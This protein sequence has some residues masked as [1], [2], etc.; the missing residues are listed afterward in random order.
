MQKAEVARPPKAL[1]QDVLQ[2]QPKESGAAHRA[3]HHLA[4]LAVAVALNNNSRDSSDLMKK[5][6][7]ATA[8][9]FAW[10]FA[11]SAQADMAVGT[12][13]KLRHEEWNRIFA[14]VAFPDEH[15]SIRKYDA[16]TYGRGVGLSASIQSGYLEQANGFRRYF[17]VLCQRQD[18][19]WTCQSPREFAEIDG[20]P[21]PIFLDAPISRIELLQLFGYISE[22]VPVWTVPRDL[23]KPIH[24]SRVKKMASLYEVD[25]FGTDKYC[26]WTWWVHSNSPAEFEAE[27]KPRSRTCI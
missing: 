8:I 5:T 9:L 26:W 15:L 11:L 22:F 25:M 3:Y 27:E 17:V 19:E 20:N 21:V 16:V 18:R 1:G 24:F 7:T 2:D 4:S 10:A 13:V 23:P 14:K 12:P 6:T